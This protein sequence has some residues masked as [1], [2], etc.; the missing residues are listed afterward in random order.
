M[1]VINV[2]VCGDFVM[3]CDVEEFVE[4][5]IVSYVLVGI[6]IYWINGVEVNVWVVNLNFKFVVVSV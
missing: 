2:I 6:L 3:L 4:C 5:C 1:D